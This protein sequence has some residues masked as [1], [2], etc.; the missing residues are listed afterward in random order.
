MDLEK[1]YIPKILHCF[2]EE[3]LPLY[4]QK[5]GKWDVT[6]IR[7]NTTIDLWSYNFECNLLKQSVNHFCWNMLTYIMTKTHWTSVFQCD[8]VCCSVMQ[9]VAVWCS[10]LQCVAVCCSVLQCFAVY[11]SVL[12]GVDPKNASSVGLSFIQATNHRTHLQS[13]ASLLIFF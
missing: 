9:C 10:V 8:A 3:N 4:S 6:L 11:C 7:A 2:W 1:Q 13:R 12:T 5:E